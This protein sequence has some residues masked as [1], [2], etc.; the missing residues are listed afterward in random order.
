MTIANVV[1]NAERAT[2]AVDTA[3]QAAEG[4]EGPIQTV[5]KMLLLPHAR[6]IAIGRG[7]AGFL[8]AIFSGC[9]LGVK[10]LDSA[11]VGVARVRD[12]VSDEV[13]ADIERKFGAKWAKEAGKNELI[14]VGWSERAKRIQGWCCYQDEAGGP[15]H[16]R[17]IKAVFLAPG[18]GIDNLG[19][20]LRVGDEAAMLEVARRQVQ[21]ARDLGLP[22]Y[23]GSLVIAH[24]ARD[25][26][27][28]RLAAIGHGPEPD[29]GRRI[30]PVVLNGGYTGSSGQEKSEEGRQEKEA[31]QV[32]KV[33]LALP[34]ANG[35]GCSA[36]PAPTGQTE[37]QGKG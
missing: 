21:Y 12:R 2:V 24:L 1:L 30:Y 9:Y 7:S 23:G 5:G 13:Q 31:R 16:D 8:T 18:E 27:H 28:T 3:V 10:D 34:H 17:E 15:F 26:I 20:T 25:Q 4:Y 14:L 37:R 6:A 36:A 33:R 19:K 29:A 32:E 35:S 11:L 22:G